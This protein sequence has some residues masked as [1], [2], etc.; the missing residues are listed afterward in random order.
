MKL[1]SP[2]DVTVL[3]WLKPELDSTL[4]QARNCLEQYVEDGQ[5]VTALRECGQ[6]LHQVAGIL[7]MVEL[8]GAA[9]LA[10]EMEQL[11]GGLA[12]D[13]AQG[14]ENA[15]SLLMQC[16]VQLPDYLERLQNGHRDVPEVLLPLINELRSIG[17][18]PPL[19]EE[20]VYTANSHCI[21]RR[22]C[23]PG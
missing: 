13:K 10:E 3:T 17:N 11:S 2:I 7:N 23:W 5:G 14:N 16:I 12:E 15:F 1:L 20:S 9:R 22:I 18:H 19:S 8:T 6:H 4:H 21:F